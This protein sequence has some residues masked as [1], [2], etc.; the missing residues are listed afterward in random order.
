M[1]NANKVKSLTQNSSTEFAIEWYNG[2]VGRISL[3][4]VRDSCPCAE[5]QGETVLMKKYAP[6]PSDRTTP[7]RYS[8]VAVEPVGGYAMKFTW[9]DGHSLGLFTWDLL[10]SLCEC[11]ECLQNRK[12]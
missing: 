1:V 2:H 7:G 8:V 10:R 9:Q 11:D 6:P 4:N 12:T 5:C 3:K